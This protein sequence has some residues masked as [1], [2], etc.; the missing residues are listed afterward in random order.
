MQR[1]T[2]NLKVVKPENELTPEQLLQKEAEAIAHEASI[3][4]YLAAQKLPVIG[5][6]PF[7]SLPPDVA[8]KIAN[9]YLPRS[10]ARR[11]ATSCRTLFYNAKL[12]PVTRRAANDVHQFLVHVKN[13][14]LEAARTMLELDPGLMLEEHSV[15]EHR[16]VTALLLATRMGDVGMCE[17]L[18]NHLRAFDS[19]CSERFKCKIDRTSAQIAN[20]FANSKMKAP[21]DEKHFDLAADAIARYP[22]DVEAELTRHRNAD[23][24]MTGL[25]AAMD[26]C[27][28]A[29]DQHG[30]CTAQDM[31][32][33]FAAFVRNGDQF[34]TY[35]QGELFFLQV[36]GYVARKVP[37]CLRMALHQGIWNLFHNNVGG[38]VRQTTCNVSNVRYSVVDFAAGTGL[39]FDFAFGVFGKH[40]GGLAS[41]TAVARVANFV[42]KQRRQL[43]NLYLCSQDPSLSVSPKK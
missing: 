28:K 39:G 41:L 26:A 40:P 27:R 13:A 6:N 4:A 30:E 8:V 7:D 15:D 23:H 1:N 21:F 42:S 43:L 25:S 35:Q 34:K 9:E 3:N 36:M 16:C 31:T 11:L 14:N 22:S 17:M 2:R 37:V 24:R 38:L 10:D 12:K 18:L 32:N 29:I 19:Q 33:V 5:Q 20:V